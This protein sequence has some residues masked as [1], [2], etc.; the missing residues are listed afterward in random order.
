MLL[1]LLPPLPDM[2]KVRW[3][4]RHPERRQ[5]AELRGH[6]APWSRAT[7]SVDTG[8]EQNALLDPLREELL[9]KTCFYKLWKTNMLVPST[10]VL[11]GYLKAKCL[12]RLTS[13]AKHTRSDGNLT[14]EWNSVRCGSPELTGRGD[15]A[16]PGWF[17]PTQHNHG[18]WESILHLF[19]VSES[20]SSLTFQNVR[21]NT[22][23]SKLRLAKQL[24]LSAWNPCSGSVGIFYRRLSES[25]CFSAFESI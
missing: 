17:T 16:G 14:S 2:G 12:F 7:S 11:G 10:Q 21:R 25:I 5:K 13:E 20:R 4:L 6:S 8:S 18:W 3:P 19:R 24:A 22:T 9:P 23:P 15:M 1:W